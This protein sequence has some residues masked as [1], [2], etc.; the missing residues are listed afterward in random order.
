MIICAVLTAL[1]SASTPLSLR[2]APAAALLRVRRSSRLNLIGWCGETPRVNRSSIISLAARRKGI[3]R[4][5]ALHLDCARS[6]KRGRYRFTREA[7]GELQS[8]DLRLI[9]SGKVAAINQF[10]V[11]G[12]IRP[13]KT[14]V[15]QN[16][17][18]Y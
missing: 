13:R 16:F 8:V 12:S 4:Y 15:Q 17:G 18:V 2:Y 9:E 10:S 3:A 5:A 11:A 1:A 7:F 6:P 14:T